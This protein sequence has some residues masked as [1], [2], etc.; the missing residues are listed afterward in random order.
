[1]P[2]IES[3][4]SGASDAIA[5]AGAS[6]RQWCEALEGLAGHWLD[7]HW[8]GRDRS[9]RDPVR[10]RRDASAETPVLV[11]ACQRL[12][13]ILDW[14]QGD[15]SRPHWLALSATIM[16][17]SDARFTL[18]GGIGVHPIDGVVE[19]RPGEDSRRG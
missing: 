10:L 19:L 4:Y 18:P 5:R 2:I 15:M 1:M 11:A 13:S 17:R 6:Q 14:S 3:K 7:E 16:G 9:G 8:S 12:W